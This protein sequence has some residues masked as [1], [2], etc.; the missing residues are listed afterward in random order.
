MGSVR[1]GSS[2]WHTGHSSS[3]A[4]WGVV[5]VVAAADVGRGGRRRLTTEGPA[6][7]E[8]APLAR[9]VATSMARCSLVR[10]RLRP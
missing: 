4:S 5:V 9:P 6:A 3:S 2:R 8:E 7:E 10:L 1:G